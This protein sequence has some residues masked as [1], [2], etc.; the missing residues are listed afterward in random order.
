MT[1]SYVRQL[2]TVVGEYPVHEL[3]ESLVVVLFLSL[4]FNEE[5]A[6]Q[7]VQVLDEEILLV[8]RDDQFDAV[9]RVF[10]LHFLKESRDRARYDPQVPVPPLLR[11]RADRRSI[12]TVLSL[13]GRGFLR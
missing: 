8:F 1:H 9:N 5:I 2:V 11:G 4:I 13:H 12:P 10:V 3:D 6:L 7:P